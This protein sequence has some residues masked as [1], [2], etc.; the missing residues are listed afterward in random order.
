KTDRNF[1]FGV[2]RNRYLMLADRFDRRVHRN[3]I[4]VETKPSIAK[5]ADYIARR[6]RAE[7]LPG[8]GGLPQHGKALA[9]ELFRHFAGFALKRKGARFKLAFHFFEASTVF[10][11]SAK[12]LAARQQKVAGKSIFDA[13]DVA[14]LAQARDTFE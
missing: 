7:Q 12:R 14:H 5:Q 10:R 11:G 3:L 13:H 2:Q 4:A 8:F 9:V 6:N 1:Y